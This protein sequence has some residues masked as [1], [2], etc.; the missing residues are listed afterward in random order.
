MWTKTILKPPFAYVGGKSIY[1][2][3]LLP[4]IPT[5]TTYVEPF[6]GSA[7]LLFAK[8]RSKVEVYNDIHPGLTTLFRVLQDPVK[9]YEFYRKAYLTTYSRE[10]F[11]NV[12]S[13]WEHCE[14]E[15]EKA[16]R[17]F[18]T[19]RF[20]FSGRTCGPSWGFSVFATS[21]KQEKMSQSC[22]RWISALNRLPDIHK[23]LEGV[24]IE[25]R[26]FREILIMYDS[27]ETFFYCDP[28]YLIENADKYYRF[29]TSVAD[30]EDLIKIL[31]NL[32]GM[33]V[34]S[35]YVHPLYETLE[36]AG[37]QRLDFQTCAP[38]AGRTRVSKILGKGAAKQRV[39]RVESVWISPKT[40][41]R[42]PSLF[43]H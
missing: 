13:N 26:D 28:P 2:N 8:E 23:R 39:P 33:A 4:L 9:F 32:K 14:D 18:V 36:E 24:I 10:E 22:A 38:A 37:W 25:E 30:H 41:E 15:V 7:A 34:V 11:H 31:L 40:L 5:H 35:G 1:L 29:A 6:G 3:Q 16:Y 21:G 20:T 19:M 42:L 17:F 43:P 12:R 27:P